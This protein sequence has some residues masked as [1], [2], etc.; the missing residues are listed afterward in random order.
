MSSRIA[1]LLRS[2]GGLLWPATGDEVE[3]TASGNTV[4][5]WSSDD[6]CIKR[7]LL[8]VELKK[9]SRCIALAATVHKREP[10]S[11]SLTIRAFGPQLTSSRR[12][13]RQG[14]RVEYS[15]VKGFDVAAVDQLPDRLR[16]LAA[17]RP[18]SLGVT[19]SITFA[20]FKV[21]PLTVTGRE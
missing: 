6:I 7:S 1:S 5:L 15:C 8:R 16:I 20:R 9:G 11:K 4:S 3:E 14:R 17:Y 18:Q 12:A 2:K 13:K 21:D 10:V 19:D